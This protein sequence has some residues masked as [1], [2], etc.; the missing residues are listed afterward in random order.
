MS[1]RGG[2]ALGRSGVTLPRVGIGCLGFGTRVGQERV[3]AV[4]DTAID[5]GVA[6]FDTADAYGFGASEIALGRAARGR[7]EQVL[8]ATKFGMS[9]NGANGPET[10]RAS[11]RYLRTA[12]A[13]SL[14]RLGTDYVDLYQLHTPD[15]VTP[16]AETLGAMSELVE[17]GLVRAIGCSNLTAEEVAQADDLARTGDWQRFVTAQNE[18]SL[19]NRSAEEAL[20]P[21][22]QERDIGVLPYF[23]L[24]YGLLSGA[25]AEGRPAAPGSRLAEFPRRLLRADWRLLERLTGFAADRGLPL[26]T[27]AI[28]YLTAQ[29]A[30]ASV[31]AGVS[32]PEQVLANAGALDWTPSAADLRELA[33]MPH[34]AASYTTFATRQPPP[35]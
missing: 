35:T 12:L 28:G 23:P 5:A 8:I 24:A 14:R 26:P 13:A 30:V 32:G 1:E 17:A 10:A 22:C 34:V 21:T 18:Y 19:Y 25:Y 15:R 33:S 20:L 11:R 9:M 6:F 4:V 27:V 29:P 7:R 2:R 31:I 16:P 3:D